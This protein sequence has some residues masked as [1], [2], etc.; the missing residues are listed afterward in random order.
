MPAADIKAGK[1]KESD[2]VRTPTG[3]YFVKSSVQK[4]LLP[5]ILTELLTAR[6]KAKKLMKS[7]TDEFETAGL[8]GRQLA[9]KVSSHSIN[10]PFFRSSYEYAVR[11]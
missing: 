4:G 11:R 3:D 10:L 8:N 7:S 1:L 2:Y 9:L 6:S 5:E